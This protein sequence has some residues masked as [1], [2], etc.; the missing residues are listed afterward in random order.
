MTPLS[1]LLLL[2]LCSFQLMVVAMPTCKLQANVVLKTHNLLRDLG[3]AF[4]VH[5]LQYNVNISFPDSAFPDATASHPQCRRALWVVYESL[6]GMQLILEQ[7]DS[8]VGEGG[9]T[10]DEG[11][12]DNFQ[13]LQ[14]R[15]LEDGSCVSMTRG[16]SGVSAG[17]G[18][19]LSHIHS[20]INSFIH[21]N[22]PPP[23]PQLSTVKGPDVFSSYFSNVT[24]VLQQQDSTVC[25]W[26]ALR[27]DVLSVLK[28]ALREHNSCFT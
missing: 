21:S 3:A 11:I 18:S 19:G 8:P 6:R 15:L 1:V 9:V 23:P 7:N 20:F 22:A 28:T 12:L 4:P 2:Q 5:C 16:S 10:W 27:R 25:G 17:P 24:D 26:M 13:N 14:H